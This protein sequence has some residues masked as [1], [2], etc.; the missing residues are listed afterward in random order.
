MLDLAFVLALLVQFT[1]GT[2]LLLRTHH[3]RWVQ[4]TAETVT[5]WLSE[6]A[7]LRWYSE[8]VNARLVA[9]V[10]TG[11]LV[12]WG[13]DLL[14][15][16]RTALPKTLPPSILDVSS[17]VHLISILILGIATVILVR[18][19]VNAPLRSWLHARGRF[20]LFLVRFVLVVAVFLAFAFVVLRWIVPWAEEQYLRNGV[21]F[22]VMMILA[23]P[24]GALG[25]ILQIHIITGVLVIAVRVLVGLAALSV[26]LLREFMWRVVEY[27]KGAWAALSLAVTT[28]ICIAELAARQSL[29]KP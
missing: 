25:A 17:E 11:V 29:F 24:F 13:V 5:L 1:K 28:I 19:K 15:M 22:D 10:D 7:V 12:F 20:W 18:R 21:P 6:V 26:W 4:T 27:N 3:Q 8:R 9:V 14:F 16:E 2:D 23:L